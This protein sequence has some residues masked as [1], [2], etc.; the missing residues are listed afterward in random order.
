MEEVGEIPFAHGTGE[1]RLGLLSSYI[2]SVSISEKLFLNASLYTRFINLL[3][4]IP[5]PN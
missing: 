2:V 4:S 5:I 3:V 1:D